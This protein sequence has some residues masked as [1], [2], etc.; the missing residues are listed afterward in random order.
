[1]YILDYNK[2]EDRALKEL[3]EDFKE[4]I[5]DFFDINQPIVAIAE[6]EI[7]NGKVIEHMDYT[8]RLADDSY[9]HF[10]FQSTKSKENLYRFLYYDASLMKK[11][12][13]NIVNT[14]IVYTNQITSA[15]EEI[16]TGCIKYTPKIVYLAD[17]A[18]DTIYKD[19]SYKIL[20]N[21]PLSQLEVINLY[22]L[23]LMNNSTSTSVR[24]LQ[25]L[26]LSTKI[27]DKSMKDKCISLLYTFAQKFVSKDIQLKIKEEFKMTEIGK[28]IIEEG[29]QE[30]LRDCVIQSLLIKLKLT[31]IPENY[32][33]KINKLSIDELK[34]FQKAIIEKINSVDNIDKYL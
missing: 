5:R 6:T 1:M 2:V 19:L 23:P 8:F 18:G 22:L 14:I 26:D 4:G 13:H 34:S 15:I 9:L 3:L 24:T 31:T 28:M 12:P 11:E 25:C 17:Y 33:D 27:K 7:N 10:E 16:S 30:G 21:I 29:R 32:I 20:N